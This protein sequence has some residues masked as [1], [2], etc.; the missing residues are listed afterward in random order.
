MFHSLSL[1]Y[2]FYII[3]KYLIF[4][5]PLNIIQINE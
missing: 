3:I 2:I 1:F 4:V 5:H